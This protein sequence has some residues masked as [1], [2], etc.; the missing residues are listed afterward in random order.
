MSYQTGSATD[1]HDLLSKFRTFITALAGWTELESVVPGGLTENGLLSVRGPGAG[2]DKQTFVTIRTEN[3]SANSIYSWAIYGALGWASGTSPGSQAGAIGPVYLSLAATSLTYWFW[4]NDRR[5]IVIAKTSTNYMSAYAGFLLP[6]ALPSE[7]PFPL[8]IGASYYDLKL[9]SHNDVNNRMIADPGAGCA[10]V[11]T[12]A[13]NVR[14]VYNHFGTTVANL[15]FSTGLRAFVWPHTTGTVDDDEIQTDVDDWGGSGIGQM[16]LNASS[17]GPLM[18]CHVVDLADQ[19]LLGALDGV[20]ALTGL[21]RSAEQI[22]TAAGKSYIMFQNIFR[23]TARDFMAIET[24]SASTVS[25]AF[26]TD[27]ARTITPVKPF[28]ILAGRATETDTAR[29]ITPA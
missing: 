12:R 24:Q 5:F 10:K 29:T 16:K 4:A 7:Y 11:R 15:N 18:Q 13:G 3:V 17:E 14:N 23:N 25:M 19:E 8:Y 27:T 21:G 2:A 1:Y 20:Y 6:F 9:P 26:E 28:S 22:L